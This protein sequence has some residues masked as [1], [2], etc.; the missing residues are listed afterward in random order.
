MSRIYS[1][2]FF[3]MSGFLSATLTSAFPNGAP[4]QSCRDL[5]PRH[6]APPQNVANPYNLVVKPV[7]QYG[8]NGALQISVE[9]S[10]DDRYQQFNSLAGFLIQVREDAT[11]RLVG[12][13]SNVPRISKHAC[14][15]R[16]AVTHT[17]N[18]QKD[19]NGL[20]FVWEPQAG[21]LQ[22]PV[23]VRVYATFVKNA[24]QYWTPVASMPI[25]IS[26]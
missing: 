19:I 23:N 18:G 7:E 11:G 17:D 15:S 10:G 3:L 26:S 20:Q 4:L 6:P 21:E 16:A 14:N 9:G 1:V 25:L 12:K 24:A 22:K 8:K 13:L 5:V 2:W